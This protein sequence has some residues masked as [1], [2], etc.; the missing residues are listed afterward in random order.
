MTLYQKLRSFDYI[1]ATEHI[2]LMP[3][4]LL[5][6]FAESCGVAI[7]LII[8]LNGGNDVSVHYKKLNGNY[9]YFLF[10]GDY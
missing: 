4:I 1:T 8:S 9:I 5:D 3:P 7:D 6:K 10:L 2:A